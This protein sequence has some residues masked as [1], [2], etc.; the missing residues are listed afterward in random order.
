MFRIQN[1]LFLPNCPPDLNLPDISTLLLPHK[2]NR[3]LNIEDKCDSEV[4]DSSYYD[5]QH[6]SMLPSD[7]LEDIAEQ[8][9]STNSEIDTDHSESSESHSNVS[10]QRSNSPLRRTNSSPEMKGEWNICSNSNLKSSEDGTQ[11]K[12]E[13]TSQTNEDSVY[14]ENVSDS[15][16]S[17]EMAPKVIETGLGEQQTKSVIRKSPRKEDKC[18]S[19][20]EES[21]PP[22]AIPSSPR[23]EESRL[24][25]RLDL[26]NVSGSASSELKSSASPPLPHSASPQL[27]V[28][29]T[30]SSPTSPPG[31][32]AGKKY[33]FSNY[34]IT[35]IYI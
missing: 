6:L 12:S 24:K 18:I 1:R 4:D 13:N 34:L 31:K 32:T 29:K 7:P 33:E 35:Y 26:S 17:R 10:H 27:A 19:I 11:T 5:Y 14:S 16:E 23:K 22:K 8:V 9:P 15:N 3:D 2:T 25:L 28:R 20:S 21:K 30:K